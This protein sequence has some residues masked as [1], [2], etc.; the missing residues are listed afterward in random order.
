MIIKKYCFVIAFFILLGGFDSSV[1]S[2]KILHDSAYYQTFHN[3]L[4]VRVY[5]IKDY[6]DF[7]FPAMSGGGDLKYRANTDYNLGLGATYLNT[8]ANLSTGVGFINNGNNDK[9]KTKSF[10]LQLHFLPRKWFGDFTYIHYKGFYAAPEGYATDPNT[11]Y[12]RPDIKTD[13]VGFDAYRNLNY[14]KLS[15]RSAFNQNEWI[16]KSAGSFLFGGGIYYQTVHSD[17]SSL[18]PSKLAQNFANPDFKK[19]HYINFGPGIGYAYTFAFAKHYFI[20]GST[21]INGNINFATDENGSLKNKRTSFEPS[22]IFK[23]SI[24]YNGSVWNVNINW[25]GDM[26]FVKQAGFSKAAIFPT[27]SVRLMVAKQI[28]LKKPIPLVSNI[29]NGIFGTDD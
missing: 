2:Q 9:G 4:T 16:K 25:A 13:A 3:V 14:R 8:N 1:Y 19:F 5:S 24:G 28:F 11:Y 7:R 27:G 20:L 23:G 21:I 10:D 12:Y 22:G 18:I 15:F 6:V 29:I 26:A 17:D